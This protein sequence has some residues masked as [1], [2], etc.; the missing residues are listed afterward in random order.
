MRI[1]LSLARIEN[2][3]RRSRLSVSGRGIRCR[4]SYQEIWKRSEI[5][6]QARKTVVRFRREISNGRFVIQRF[7]I[8]QGSSWGAQTLFRYVYL[9]NRSRLLCFLAAISKAIAREEC[10]DAIR[11]ERRG[12]CGIREANGSS[13][14]E[15]LPLSKGNLSNY[16]IADHLENFL[17]NRRRW[18]RVCFSSEM[19]KRIS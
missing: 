19:E 15:N 13:G 9:R 16:Q 2:N 7:A 14:F 5:G 6:F 8:S 3:L 18:D 4:R 11:R 17:A 12:R 1:G 10:I